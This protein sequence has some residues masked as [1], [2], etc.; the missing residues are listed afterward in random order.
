MTI[1]SSFQHVDLFKQ[2]SHITRTY[3]AANSNISQRMRTQGNNSKK[4]FFWYQKTFFEIKITF[5]V[6]TKAEK[7][8]FTLWMINYD[9]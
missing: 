1:L 5:E 7:L 3:D 4:I 9:F 2:T 8:T 6:I